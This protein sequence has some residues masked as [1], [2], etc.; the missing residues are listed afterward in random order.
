MP[1][2]RPE[3]II[4]EML[5]KAGTP[6]PDILSVGG[7]PMDRPDEIQILIMA[8]QNLEHGFL[9]LAG[10]QEHLGIILDTTR[11][12]LQMIMNIMIEKGIISKEDANERYKKEVAEEIMRRQKAAQEEVM[13]QVEQAKAEAEQVKKEAMESVKEAVEE[14]VGPSKT[15]MEQAPF[16]SDVVLPSERAGQVIRFPSKK[17]E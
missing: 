14:N 17:K 2:K 5:R 4:A 13:K 12:T 3:D 1:K 10:G 11:L 6:A 7:Q 15:D 8:V 16:K 9:Q